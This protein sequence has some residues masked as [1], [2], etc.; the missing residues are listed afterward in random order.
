MILFFFLIHCIVSA[1]RESL[2]AKGDLCPTLCKQHSSYPYPCLCSICPRSTSPKDSTRENLHIIENV[3]RRCH[4]MCIHK[5][6]PI[7]C[8][9][10]TPGYEQYPTF[11]PNWTMRYLFY[12]RSAHN[13]DNFFGSKIFA[14]WGTDWFFTGF[15]SALLKNCFLKRHR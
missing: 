8:F 5:I 3:S 4:M 1:Q 11:T 12:L 13:S 10:C 7:L 2:C 14:P 15:S 9:W 6:E